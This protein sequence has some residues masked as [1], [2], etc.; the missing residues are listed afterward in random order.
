MRTGI[1]L[2]VLVLALLPAGCMSLNSSQQT[3]PQT[4]QLVT[5]EGPGL[6]VETIGAGVLVTRIQPMPGYDTAAMAYRESDHEIRYY[7]HNR[8]SDRP[9]RQ[10]QPI[11]VEYLENIGL[12]RTVLASPATVGA[13]YRLEIELLYL[14]QDL[15]QEPGYARLGLRVRLIE[16]AEQRILM[17]RTIR[18][19]AEMREPGPRAGVAAANLALEQ[20]LGTL[21]EALRAAM[22]DG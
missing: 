16:Q 22:Q 19:R 6:R 10:L 7:A 2:L 20:A 21:A 14:E 3:H 9:A 4:W 15:R 18:T 1:S 8:W 17:N 13:E 11:L 12:Y 5:P